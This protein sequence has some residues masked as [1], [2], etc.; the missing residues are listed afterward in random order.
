MILSISTLLPSCK[1]LDILSTEDSFYEI[2]WNNYDGT[3]LEKDTVKKGELPTY[4][5]PTPTKEDNSGITYKFV[6]WDK[7]IVPVEFNTTYTA[8]FDDVKGRNQSA[9]KCP[10]SWKNGN[11]LLLQDL[12]FYYNDKPVYK[13]KEPTKDYL[14]KGDYVIMYKF[15]GWSTDPQATASE[16]IKEKDLPN[17]TKRETYFA[18]FSEHKGYLVTFMDQNNV[19]DQNVFEE[20]M[21]P[22]YDKVDPS[23]K[24]TTINGVKTNFTFCG[25]S[26]DS[27]ATKTNA[28]LKENLPVVTKKTTYHAIYEESE[29]KYLV[30]YWDTA[31]NFFGNRNFHT[32]TVYEGEKPKF[33]TDKIPLTSC[34]PITENGQ[35]K[36]KIQNFVGWNE[37]RE[38]SVDEAIPTM[39]LPA[40]YSMKRYFT[41]Y[42]KRESVNKP[43]EICFYNYIG[44]SASGTTILL[45]KIYLFTNDKVKY[46]GKLPTRPNEIIG[47]TTKKFT[48]VG[49]NTIEYGSPSDALQIEDLPNVNS[50]IN[51][52]AQYRFDNQTM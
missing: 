51:Y 20:G 6:G 45:A 11:E 13:G 15:V 34:Y 22:Q 19:F 29:A 46:Y 43:F 1:V 5:G 8:V 9:V 52:Y 33:D 50:S 30:T 48:F 27:N 39:D 42:D 40:V 14:D 16:A 26:E 32:D 10:V 17:L 23:K 25:W 38:A 18:I 44:N 24:T 12:D 47:T 49:W 37:K 7:E 41:I 28:I 36:Y 2:I 21:K 35:Q 4:D 3:L 31:E